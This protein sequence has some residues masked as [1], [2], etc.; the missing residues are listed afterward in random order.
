[1]VVRWLLLGALWLAV[2]VGVSA[3]E[4][5][6][7]VAS[8]SQGLEQ[9]QDQPSSLCLLQ[10]AKAV[11]SKVAA[12]AAAAAQRA[13]VDTEAAQADWE[14]QRIALASLFKKSEQRA[15]ELRLE[16]QERERR[17]QAELLSKLFKDSERRADELR[18]SRAARN[19]N[20]SE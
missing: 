19:Q 13:S 17:R 16:R 14:R 20:R 1:M 18:A 7:A 12:N 9:D 3:E 8:E 15:E 2:V 10:R 4:V 5:C 11:S 6:D